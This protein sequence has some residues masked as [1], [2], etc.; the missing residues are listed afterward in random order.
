M[1]SSIR[2]RF[3]VFDGR[4]RRL[5]SYEDSHTSDIW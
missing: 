4:S 5:G 3:L 2:E 1:S